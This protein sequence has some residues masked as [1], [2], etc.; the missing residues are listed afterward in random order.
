MRP[1][2]GNAHPTDSPSA[3]NRTM[4]IDNRRATFGAFSETPS[5]AFARSQTTAVFR[6][7]SSPSQSGA[8]TRRGSSAPTERSQGSAKG[9]DSAKSL[10]DAVESYLL[11]IQRVG[12]LSREQES[13]VAIKIDHHRKRLRAQLLE[14]DF[15]LRDAIDLLGQVH[16]GELRFDRF[17]QVAVSDRLEK[18]QIEGRMPHN[19]HTL[20]ALLRL[21]R[22]DYD[23]AISTSSRRRRDALWA[24]IG[25]RRR[26]AI[27]LV[28]EL[29]LRIEFLSRQTGKLFAMERRVKQLADRGDAEARAE[30]SEILASVQ[31][32]PEGLSRQVAKIRSAQTQFNAAKNELC[33]S[34]LRLVVSIAKKYRNRGLAFLD[35]IQEGNAGLI[36]AVEKFEHQRGFK[37]CTYATW[38]IRQAITRAI[39]DQ[40]RTIRVPA[41]VNPEITRMKR[42]D[43]DLRH[44]LGR[45]PSGDEI[46]AAAETSSEQAEAILRVSQNLASLQQPIGLDETGELG[47][48]VEA[49]SVDRPDRNT[50]LRMLHQRLHR[51]LEERLSWRE[52]E[53]LKMRFGL[54][55]G[56]EYTLTE[57][58]QVFNVSRERVRQI[59]SRALK[60]LSEGQ[61]NA[62]LIGFVD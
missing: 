53:I 25:N 23:Q 15:V 2:C 35:L 60:K 14:A 34:N 31:Q 56:H 12:L 42:I 62:E 7:D 37:F 10:D 43:T 8:T 22:H 46:A 11:R 54:G 18:D 48:L 47:D 40:G 32:T 5:D 1:F 6:Q 13:E 49:S 4:S 30:F 45:V 17:I 58:S 51:I 21:N 20:E 26:R 41:H 50:D 61:S 3:A 52:R 16:R 38:W 39:C 27:Q 44:Q 19:L 33:E 55:D 24:K 36:R 59:E 29:G 57:V 28:E 9:D